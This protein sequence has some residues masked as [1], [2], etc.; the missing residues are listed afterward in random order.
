MDIGK[1][2]ERLAELGVLI[3]LGSIIAT[4]CLMAI[5]LGFLVMAGHAVRW[6]FGADEPGRDESE[7]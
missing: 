2:L 6:L 5:T 1:G 3:V 4:L 7:D